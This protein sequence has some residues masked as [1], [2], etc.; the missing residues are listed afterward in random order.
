MEKFFLRSIKGGLYLALLSPVFFAQRFIY[1][2]I[3][4]KIFFFQALAEIIFGL[5]LGL[6]IF[7][8]AYR[9]KLTR[10][11]LVLIVFLGVITFSSLLGIDPQRSFWST[12]DRGLGLVALF[13]FGALFLMLANLKHHINWRRYF[14]ATFYVSL[15]VS[16]FAIVQVYTPTFFLESSTGRPGSFLGNPAFLA[17]YLLFHI[18]LGLWL[19]FDF[20]RERKKKYDW[21]ALLLILGVGVEIFVLFLSK[22]RGAILSFGLGILVT[23]VYLAFTRKTGGPGEEKW[24]K[25]GALALVVLIL[26]TGFTFWFTRQDSFWQEVPILNRFTDISFTSTDAQPRVIAWRIAWQSF[27]ERPVLGFGLEN[28]KYPFDQHYNPQLLKYGF[29]ETYFDKP[30][31]VFFEYLVV[32]G[33]LGLLAYLALLG[34]FVYSLFR[35]PRLRLFLPLGLGLFLA[36][37]GQNFFIFDTFG[38]FL[39]FFVVL[40]F[41]DSLDPKR[42]VTSQEETKELT[43]SLWPKVTGVILLVGA[44]ALLVFFLN[45]RT[46]YANNRQYWGANYFLNRMSVPALDA[47][48]QALTTPNPYVNDT[49]RSFISTLVQIYAQGIQIPDIE[50]VA[51]KSMSELALAI[52]SHPRDFFLR[53]TFADIG[54]VFYVFEP[55]YLDLAE[56]QIQLAMKLSPKRQS[57]YYVAAKLKLIRGASKEALELMRQAV[58]LDEEV[59]DPHFYYAMTAFGAG[60]TSLGFKE[61]ELAKK[62]GREPRTNEELRVLANFYGEAGGYDESIRLYKEALRFNPD[63]IESELKLGLV[64]YRSKN[65]DLAKETLRVVAGKVDLK[66]SPFYEELKLIYDRLELSIGD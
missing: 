41:I 22:T 37:V 57:V 46:L 8:P 62:L 15:F 39:M 20:Y 63:D 2:F 60:D 17:S 7:Y 56:D 43:F 36:Y 48:V 61:I 16:L 27:K 53:Y 24:L 19:A 10:L 6:I 44:A 11:T 51:K 49:R 9:P 31:N 5:W 34:V 28:F 32:G 45:I 52:K 4:P 40:A 59:G 65:W 42:D 66:Q 26:A 14:T 58:Q 23:L 33:I 50:K 21:R 18:F 12:Q 25:R 30:H 64:Y 55:K 38:S 29:T 47:Y 3:T 13:H 1:P 35:F 54:S